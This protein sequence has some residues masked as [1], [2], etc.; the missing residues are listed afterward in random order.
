MIVT[1]I[2][3]KFFVTQNFNVVYG[4]HV[5]QYTNFILFHQF[6]NITNVV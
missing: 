3:K 5:E 4:G 2:K 6:L 1:L